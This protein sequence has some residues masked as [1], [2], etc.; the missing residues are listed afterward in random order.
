V[1]EADRSERRVGELAETVLGDH[2][3][4]AEDLAQAVDV[5][6]R[7][8]H[9]VGDLDRGKVRVVAAL[10]AGVVGDRRARQK[11][12]RHRQREYRGRERNVAPD[13]ETE[14]GLS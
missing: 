9:A 11:E 2:G 5:A 3:P 10:A 8:L 12:G 7:T 13:G 4:A 14:H 6:A 1:Q